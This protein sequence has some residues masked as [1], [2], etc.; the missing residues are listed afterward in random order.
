MGVLDFLKG[1][2]DKPSVDLT[3]MKFISDDHIRYERGKDVSGH[4]TN[5]WR[6]IRVQ[7]NISGGQAYTVTMYNL[8]ENHSLWDNNIQMAPKQMKVI[9]QSN[10]LIKLRGYGTDHIGASF[11]DYGLTL[12]INNKVI[13]K[14]TLHMYDRR[15]DIVYFKASNNQLQ[16]NQPATAKQSVPTQ[17][18]PI[19]STNIYEIMALS[20]VI[21]QTQ[22]IE[23]LRKVYNEKGDYNHPQI[24]YDFG[25]A[26]LIKGDKANAKKALTQGAVYGIQYPCS[27]YGN[28]L[29]D[30]VGQCLS[31]LMTN[32]S[33]SD[34]A[35]AIKITALGYIFLSRCI[36]L[37]LREA[38]DSYRTRALLFKDHQN[39][40]V[41]Q[42]LIMENVGM[43]VV[44]EPYII[45]DFYITSQATDS[46]YQSVIQSARRIHQGLEDMTIGGKDA[47][48]YSLNEMA[49]FGEKRHL[50]LFKILEDKYKA[51]AFN[52]TI[53]QLKNA[54]R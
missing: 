12:H 3:D 54:I 9:E 34:N 7:N 13:E 32:F 35:N 46:P 40:M 17:T 18:I 28:A 1:N 23:T 2:S 15:V 38:H 22:D 20:Q 19:P 33:I 14:I 41:V 30:S 45:S 37:Y 47:D 51:G 53:E 43:G 10:F 50:L 49:E 25:A 16:Q 36:E 4:N 6:G 21:Q 8:D 11:A 44:I 42:S 39:P 27:L 5:C 31:L 24:C 26:F 29:V 52:L 48:D